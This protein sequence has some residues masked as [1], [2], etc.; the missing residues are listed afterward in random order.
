MLERATD[1]EVLARAGTR[2]LIAFAVDDR[3]AWRARLMGAGV[4]I[5]AETEHSLYFRDPDGRRLAVS[6]YPLTA[7]AD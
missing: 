1:D 4:T 7:A 3:G 6:T 2:E 5:E